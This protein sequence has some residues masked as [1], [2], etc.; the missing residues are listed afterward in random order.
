[1]AAADE[2]EIYLVTPFYVVRVGVGFEAFLV[3]YFAIAA[4]FSTYEEHKVVRGS[5][6]ADVAQSVGYL[7]ANGVVV[8]KLYSW[9]N[10]LFDSL[11]DELEFI[12]RLG[13]L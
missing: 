10:T 4:F 2:R 9:G 1:L 13:C 5:E 11:H 12:E 6:G 3:E 7:T 8:M